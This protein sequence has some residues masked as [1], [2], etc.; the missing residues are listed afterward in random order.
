MLRATNHL[1]SLDGCYIIARDESQ[2][3]RRKYY[4]ISPKRNICFD[5]KYSIEVNVTRTV[6]S[7]RNTAEYSTAHSQIVYINCNLCPSCCT[8]VWVVQCIPMLVEKLDKWF[9]FLSRI[10]WGGAPPRPPRL[11]NCH[12][13]LHDKVSLSP[14]PLVEI[15][16]S[17]PQHIHK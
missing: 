6:S 15:L 2:R 5:T 17:T 10:H 16:L 13:C 3:D 4:T 8:L 1:R 7:G 14:F 11:P 12:N 9:R